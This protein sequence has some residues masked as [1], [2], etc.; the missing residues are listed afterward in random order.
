MSE[1]IETRFTKLAIPEHLEDIADRGRRLI[2]MGALLS[3]RT[4]GADNISQLPT[5]NPHLVYNE[6]P[7]FVSAQW[8]RRNGAMLFGASMQGTSLS[9]RLNDFEAHRTRTLVVDWWSIYERHMARAIDYAPTGACGEA[10]E[11]FTRQ[12]DEA[13][14]LSGLLQAAQNTPLQRA[15]EV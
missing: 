5:S 7:N 14:A 6:T 8:R 1:S 2:G 11:E 4:D 15:A 9:L 3:G 13:I 10:L 12:Y